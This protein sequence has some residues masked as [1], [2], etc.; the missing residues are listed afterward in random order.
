MN[1]FGRKDSL[2]R[3]VKWAFIERVNSCVNYEVNVFNNSSFVKDHLS[4]M[5]VDSAKG[6]RSY[7]GRMLKRVA[8]Y[9]K[10]A[11]YS[12]FLHVFL[13]MNVRFKTFTVADTIDYIAY[14]ALT[15]NGSTLVAEIERRITKEPAKYLRCL[16]SECNNC[17]YSLLCFVNSEIMPG[18]P[19]GSCTDNCFM[20]SQGSNNTHWGQN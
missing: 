13:S 1:R 18:L 5:K 11:F 6:L 16:V 17:M 9:Q 19:I 20:F 8:H 12:I 14:S 10:I 15:C 4:E 3:V 7:Q 2:R